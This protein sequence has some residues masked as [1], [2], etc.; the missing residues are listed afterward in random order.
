MA[1]LARCARVRGD[2]LLVGFPVDA[3]VL[4]VGV[5]RSGSGLGGKD[6]LPDRAALR[7]DF[8]MDWAQAVGPLLADCDGAFAVQFGV[9][10][11]RSVLIDQVGQ[12]VGS[13]L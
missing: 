11:F 7:I 6:G 9:D 10:G 12:P 8:P 5:A 3:R 2:V 4:V 1:T 13:L